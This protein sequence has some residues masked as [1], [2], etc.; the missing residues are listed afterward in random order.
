MN[1]WLKNIRRRSLQWLTLGLGVKRWLVALALGAGI[2][3]M[4]VVYLILLLRR[5]GILPASLYRIIT[6]QALPNW[7]RAIVPL[8]LGGFIILLALSRYSLSVMAPFRKEG[9]P[10]IDR[11]YNYRR[12][13]KGPHI[14]AIGGGTGLSTLLRGLINHTN[15]ITAIVTVADDGG[16]SGRIRQELGLLP[17]GDI[18]N[19]MAALSRDEALMTQLLR[20]RF[21]GNPNQAGENSLRGHSF[22]NLLLAALADIAGS[23]DE[24]LL[25]AERVL[26]LQGRVMPATLQ[27]V[28]LVAHIRTA[29]DGSIQRIVGESAIPKTKGTIEKLKLEPDDV[30]AYPPTIQAILQAD[31]IL[32]GPGSLYTSVAPNLLIPDMAKAVQHARA[33][34]LYICNVAT[35]PGETDGF[36]VTDHLTAL[37]KI[38]KLDTIDLVV[39]NDN[40]NAGNQQNNVNTTYVALTPVPN[41]TL[42]TA[43][44][45]DDAKPWRHD[46]DKLAGAV[47]DWLKTA[48][49][50]K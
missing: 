44:L 11:L 10:V 32:L 31:L 26:A 50:R 45:V 24:G 37:K 15:N 13:S 22:G 12:R 21:G 8:L 38:V 17:P 23:F 7:G 34:K 39:A 16:S 33:P 49:N 48:P 47:M 41:A 46:S 6:F 5:D 42:I 35:Q 29:K 18:R 43:D 9:E 27:L 3:G 2:M 1:S 4:G 19:N 14:V 30:R 36:N 40:F 20:Y 25:A 28:R